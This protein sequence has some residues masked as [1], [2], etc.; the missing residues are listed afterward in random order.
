MND[1]PDLADR[2]AL[3]ILERG[4]YS[5]ERLARYVRARRVDVVAAMT[6]DPRFVRAGAG[7]GTRWTLALARWDGM[8]R[9]DT[10][11]SMSEDG[12]TVAA[13][14]DDLERRIVELERRL[15][16]HEAPA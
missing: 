14:L 11:G 13:R 1:R 16:E 15:A 5:G 10:A 2:L 9:E 12:T 4:P 6:A 3:A 8:G 7:R